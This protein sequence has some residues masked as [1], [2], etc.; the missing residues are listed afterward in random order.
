MNQATKASAEFTF[1]FWWSKTKS[2]IIVQPYNNLM[3]E[4][5]WNKKMMKHVNG[6]LCVCLMELEQAALYPANM[7]ENRIV[8]SKYGFR[9]HD[10]RVSS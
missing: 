2:I 3:I 6:V 5:E 4:C 1:F 8:P 10:V 7:F 9:L